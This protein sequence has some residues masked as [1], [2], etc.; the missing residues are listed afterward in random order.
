MEQIKYEAPAILEDVNLEVACGILAQSVVTK[1][2]EVES[3]GQEVVDH[4]MAP[5]YEHTWE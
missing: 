5:G 3:V 4:A 1:N 2:K